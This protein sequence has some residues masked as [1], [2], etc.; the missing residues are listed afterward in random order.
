MRG[1]AGSIH[2]L[3]LLC[4]VTG[5]GPALAQP[6]DAGPGGE[7]SLKAEAVTRLAHSLDP[8]VALAV[9]TVV[10]RQSALLRAREL[11]AEYG[12]RADLGEGW[13]ARAPEWRS[14]EEELMRDVAPMIVTRVQSPDWFYAVLEREIAVALDA[15]E[16]DYI[17]SHFTTK[18]GDEQR[19]LLQMR[20]LG[21]VLMTNYS[22]TN[23]IDHTVPG[24]EQDLRALS[25]AYWALEPFRVRDFMND[26]QAIKFAGQSAGLKFTRMLAIRGIEGFI[27]HIDATALAARRAVDDAEPVI[28][29]HIAAY[30]RRTGAGERL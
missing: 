23:R 3:V 2:A 1:V 22:F 30:R 29:A 9:G 17:A 14:A 12:E 28:E 24:L 13:N 20:L 15:E 4:L 16:A 8:A 21:E 5:A 26:P 7:Q 18:V 27:A 10:V 6:S 11:L 19:I 25:Q